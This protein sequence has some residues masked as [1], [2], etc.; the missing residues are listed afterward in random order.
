MINMLVINSLMLMI[1]IDMF[2]IGQTTQT[3]LPSS[4]SCHCSNV[5]VQFPLNT[6][7]VMLFFCQ[8]VRYPPHSTHQQKKRD[9]LCVCVCVCV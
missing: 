1:M 5:N 6:K 9:P 4:L 7:T 2:I 3:G 8:V